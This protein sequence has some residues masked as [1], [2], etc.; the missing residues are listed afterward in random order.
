MENATLQM[1]HT[2]IRFHQDMIWIKPV[3]DFFQIDVRN[4]HKK[5]KNDPILQKL[6]GKNTPDFGEID[7]NGRILLTKKGFL[8]WIQII[9][10]NTITKHL[11]EKF[12][13]F[14]LL[15]FDYLLGSFEN[16][17]TIR[18][19]YQRLSK[20]K[21]LKMKIGNEITRCETAINDYLSGRFLQTK[22]DFTPKAIEE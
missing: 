10:P 17:D 20:L 1:F 6:V 14:Q 7:N 3:C 18:T 11:Q 19:H 8:R 22:L 12:I 2:T 9:N 4:Q 15:V 21:R 16:E 5:I 13:Q